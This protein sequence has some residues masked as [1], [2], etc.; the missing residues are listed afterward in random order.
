MMASASANNTSDKT[1]AIRPTRDPSI[2]PPQRFQRVLKEPGS[3]KLVLGR[4]VL[5]EPDDEDAKEKG[6]VQSVRGGGRTE[7]RGL[8]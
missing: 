5:V 1:G 2:T 4:W 3:K 8:I 7:G 6:P